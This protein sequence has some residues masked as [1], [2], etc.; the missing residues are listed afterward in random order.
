MWARMRDQDIRMGCSL[1]YKFSERVDQS[2]MRWL[3][4]R[5]YRAEMNGMRGRGRPITRWCEKG[6]TI[7]RAERCVQLCMIEKKW[8]SIWKINV[9]IIFEEP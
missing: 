9:L 3:V 8:R 2:V 4:K 7:Q 1:K 6:M 5:I